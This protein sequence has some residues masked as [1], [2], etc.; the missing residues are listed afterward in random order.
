[1]PARSSLSLWRNPDLVRILIGETIS[2]LGS[3]VGSLALPLAAALTLQAT[4]GQMAILGIAE[5]VPPILVGLIAGVWIDRLR[6]RPLLIGANLARALVLVVLAIA[7]ATHVL[8]VDVLYAAGVVLGALNVMFVTAFAAYLPSLV[9][10][11]SLV[12]A[13]A[14]RATGSAAADVVGP[15][16]AGVLIQVLGTA[17]A[18]AVD[19][20]SFLASVTGLA[21]VRTAEPAPRPRPARR[22]LARELVEGWQ[23]L[24]GQPMLRAFTLTAF[25]ANFFYRIVMTVYV[26]Y[27]IRDLALSPAVIGLIFGF[28]GGA[29]VLLGSASA[30]AVSRRFGLG[31]TLVVAH[32]LFGVFGLPLALAIGL[33]W[34]AA[35]LV[36]VSEFTQLSVNAVYMVNRTSVEQALTPHHLQGRV[37]G[38]RTVSHAL[39]GTVGLI[40]GGVL[41]ER[42]GTSVAVLV[43]VLG[44]LMSFLWLWRSPI[45]QLQ[46]F[47]DVTG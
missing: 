8:S 39:A 7:S 5:Y 28:G 35:P 12:T 13:N 42:F 20:A 37:Q 36:F 3:Q 1:V 10:P 9:V 18:L 45:R 34:L 6:R 33:P 15:A 11:A 44:G 31:R 27:L 19:G 16:V 41:G 26:L 30:G 17:G 29:G 22:R 2:D 43:G 23:L 32:V 4:P 25:T 38:S 24:L 40:V 21:L 47:S 46:H 14:A